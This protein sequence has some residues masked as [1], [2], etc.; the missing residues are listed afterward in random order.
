MEET[1]STLRYAERAKK[2]VTQPTVNQDPRSKLVAELRA[3]ISL[4]K[5]QLVEAAMR[6]DS[7]SAELSSIIERLRAPEEQ[8]ASLLKSD[9]TRHLEADLLG[10]EN[11]RLL[12]M[13]GEL[14]AALSSST[15]DLGVRDRQLREIFTEDSTLQRQ[16]VAAQRELQESEC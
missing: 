6:G 15:R 10:K 3:E 16:M 7:S 14:S 12:S 9:E 13:N 2:V 1:K 5:G 4:L 8:S 11:A